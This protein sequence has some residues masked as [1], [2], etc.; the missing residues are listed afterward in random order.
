LAM[1][2]FP[3]R[4]ETPIK[5]PVVSMSGCGAP[6]AVAQALL[7]AHIVAQISVI[8]QNGVCM[9]Q[10]RH[11]P[12]AWHRSDFPRFLRCS[13]GKLWSRN[14]R[15]STETMFHRRLKRRCKGVVRSASR[16]AWIRNQVPA[17]L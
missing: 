10:G 12:E 7:Q 14:E 3:N 15:N 17:G 6:V 13:S 11:G 5:L 4:F 9:V 16:F 8:P 2:A 1:S